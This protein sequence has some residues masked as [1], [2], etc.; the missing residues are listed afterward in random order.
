MATKTKVKIFTMIAPYNG[1]ADFGIKFDLFHC[2]SI[3][4]S[5]IILVIT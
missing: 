5:D 1:V 2:R 3:F 4:F